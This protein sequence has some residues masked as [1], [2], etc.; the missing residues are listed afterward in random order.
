[1]EEMDEI[2]EYEEE[3]EKLPLFMRGY[4]NPSQKKLYLLEND[5]WKFDPIPEFIDGKNI[6]D[7][8]DP[9]ILQKLEEL[10]REEEERLAQMEEQMDVDDDFVELTQEQKQLVE[11][12]KEKKKIDN[13]KTSS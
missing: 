7:F 2:D 3:Q 8:I 6:A 11:E 5:D 12:I 9:D 4:R 13:S 1:M 10:E